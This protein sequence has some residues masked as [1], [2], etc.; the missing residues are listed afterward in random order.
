MLYY[1]QHPYIP[2]FEIIITSPNPLNMDINKKYPPI[3]AGGV[4]QG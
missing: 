4:L 3:K 1:I 2:S